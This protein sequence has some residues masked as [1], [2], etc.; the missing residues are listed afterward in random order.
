MKRPYGFTSHLNHVALHDAQL[1]AVPGHEVVNDPHVQGGLTRAE[2]SADTHTH[3]WMH[4]IAS[5]V[6][7]P[8]VI[9]SVAIKRMV[10]C[11]V[12]TLTMLAVVESNDRC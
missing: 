9:V 11:R 7:K 6:L 12:I 1:A 8:K 10:Y 2:T 3:G 4:E 5:V